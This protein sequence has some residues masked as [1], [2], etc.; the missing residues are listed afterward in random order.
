[1]A[2]Q[3]GADSA[4]DLFTRMC[5]RHAG[6]LTHEATSDMEQEAFMGMSFGTTNLMVALAEELKLPIENAQPIFE[7]A[8]NAK[9]EELD[10]LDAEEKAA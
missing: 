4:L 2:Q 6:F 9:L 5:Q 1:M 3:I 7:A 10:A 8:I